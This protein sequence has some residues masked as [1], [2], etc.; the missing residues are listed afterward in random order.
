MAGYIASFYSGAKVCHVEAINVWEL[1]K[2]ANKH[3]R[4]NI[5]QPGCGVG[6]HCIAVDPYFIISKFPKESKIISNA[7][8]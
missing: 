3:P 5:L 2:L 6:G 1:I 4:V 8:D 7:R